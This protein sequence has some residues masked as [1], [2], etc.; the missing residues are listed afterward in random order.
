MGDETYSREEM[1]DILNQQFKKSAPG[2]LEQKRIVDNIV[3]LNDSRIEE[4]KTNAGYEELSSRMDAAEAEAEERKQKAKFDFVWDVVKTTLSV[5]GSIAW[6]ML[7]ATALVMGN[8][9]EK[10]GCN[11]TSNT[12]KSVFKILTDNMRFGR[13]K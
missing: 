7:S 4:E 2:S 6:F 8:E 3:K 1:I 5:G 10:G 12:F 11:P 9:I 13:K